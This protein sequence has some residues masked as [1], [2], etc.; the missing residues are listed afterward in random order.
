MAEKKIIRRGSGPFVVSGSRLLQGDVVWLDAGHAWTTTLESAAL[1]ET[2]EQADSAMS[3]ANAD[4]R[5]LAVVDVHIVDV[6]VEGGRIVPVTSR[7]KVRAFGPTITF[8]AQALETL[9][10]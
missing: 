8:G 5:Q 4:R 10:P 1:L 3:V 7:E 6:I 9:L 2:A